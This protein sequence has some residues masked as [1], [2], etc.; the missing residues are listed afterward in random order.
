M[1][2]ND[3][4]WREF[5]F[6]VETI[7][8]RNSSDV[9]AGITVKSNKLAFLHY[10]TSWITNSSTTSINDG[11]WHHCVVTNFSNQ[12]GDLWVDGT[13]ELDGSSTTLSPSS[14]TRYLKLDSVFRGYNGSKY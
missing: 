14:G 4:Y 10:N 2:K 11:N 5:N 9:W 13:K 6:W 8:G 7:I 1:D 3:S 12:T